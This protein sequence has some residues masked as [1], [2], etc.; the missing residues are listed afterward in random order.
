MRFTILGPLEVSN[1]EGRQVVVS[2]RLHRSALALLL[3][4]AGKPHSPAELAG[5]L[6]GDEPPQSPEVSLRSCVYGIRKLLPEAGRLR[7]HPA[8][9]LIDVRP[10]ELDLHEFRTL[11]AGGR[12]ALDGGDARSA[13]ELLAGALGLWREPA[14]ADVP[15]VPDK[16]RLLDQRREA[17]DALTDARLALGQHRQVLTELRSAVTADP[18]REHAWAQLMTA[19]YRCGARAE[20]LDAFSRLRLALVSAYG[21]EPGPELQDLHRRVLADDP[22]LASAT[23]AR[24]VTL[25]EPAYGPTG[26]ADP[27]WLASGPAEPTR[28]ASGPTGPAGPIRPAESQLAWQSPCQLPASVPDFTGRAAE[29]GDLLG[30][31]PGEGMA[32]TVVTGMLGAGKTALAI[33]A[34]HIA[35]A[36]FPD[37]QLYACLDDAGQPRDPQVVLGELLRGLGVPS[38]GIPA[39]GFERAAVYRSVLAGRRVLVVA[40][41]ASSSAQV[42]PLLPGTPGSAVVVTS[43]ARL[44][45]LDAA[46]LV[47]LGT[48]LPADSAALVTRIS[49]RDP[50]GPDADATA[51]IALA[52]GHLPL[53]LRIAGARLAEDPSLTADALAGLLASERRRLDELVVG[54]LSVRTRLAEAAQAL[55]GEGRRALALLAAAGPR[56]TTGS[57]IASLLED[58][59][60]RDV[61]LALADAGLLQRIAG[62]G[63]S[64]GISYRMHSLVR[65]FARELLVKADPG[66][67]GSAT[68]RLLAWRWLEFA[69]R[70]EPGGRVTVR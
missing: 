6:W 19:L 46:R 69:N 11:A 13:A 18:L 15:A 30:R 44:A 55:S 45:D 32:V 48:L 25:T 67:V 65:A 62:N 60:A 21:I 3:L 10:D 51:A 22:S 5:S 42:R 12:D 50:V 35:R 53:A 52:C 26:P 9:Y 23:Q 38:E 24:P 17:Q 56:E 2:R 41:S 1:D 66:L 47:E 61:A 54:E 40:D 64:A 63:P 70:G 33:H 37:G 49:G 58:S 68:G 20:A 43:R 28:L 36:C 39:P 4:N 59:G 16:N 31:L 57:L 27:T 14:L 29:L 8:G 7:T 34:A